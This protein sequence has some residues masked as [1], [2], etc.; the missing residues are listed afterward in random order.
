[1]ESRAASAS[2]AAMARA[3]AYRAQGSE[4]TAKR[5][6][7]AAASAERQAPCAKEASDWARQPAASSGASPDAASASVAT[8]ATVNPMRAIPLSAG[9]ATLRPVG[10]SAVIH[11]SGFQV[12]P[13]L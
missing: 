8:N 11:D 3:Q 6:F 5:A 4:G 12:A 2:T 7:S 9:S 13:H 10:R 1:M